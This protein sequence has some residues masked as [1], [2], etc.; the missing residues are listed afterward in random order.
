MTFQ[1]ADSLNSFFLSMIQLVSIITYKKLTN[2]AGVMC[3]IL[4]GMS[5]FDTAHPLFSLLEFHMGNIQKVLINVN[6]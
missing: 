3:L 2:L 4:L 6:Y 1:M 5:E